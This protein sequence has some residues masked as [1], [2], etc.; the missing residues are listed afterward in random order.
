MATA[1]LS[2]LQVLETLLKAG[3][4]VFR[5]DADDW[6]ALHF[7]GAPAPGFST[8]QQQRVLLCVSCI[9][10]IVKQRVTESSSC[11]RMLLSCV[12]PNNKAAVG[13]MLFCHH[14]LC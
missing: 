2:D 11:W 10:S 8:S 13:I 12:N 14:D 3:A 5:K 7:A 6:S 9:F 1:L 4:D